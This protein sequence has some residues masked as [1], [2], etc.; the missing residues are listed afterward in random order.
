MYA[1]HGVSPEGI[2]PTWTSIYLRLREPLPQPHLDSLA[3]FLTKT[4][5][6]TRH[7]ES[8]AVSLAPTTSLFK[9]TKKRST[10]SELPIRPLSS[11]LASLTS[12]PAG[13]F[14]IETVE[15]R[16]IQLDLQKHYHSEESRTDRSLLTSIWSMARNIAKEKHVR[17][18]E[19]KMKQPGIFS[20]FLHIINVS[21]KVTASKSLSSAMQRVTKKKPPATCDLSL[22]YATYDEMEAST[23][24]TH[25]KHPVLAGILPDP[26]SGKI[27][28]GFETHQTTGCAVHMAGPFIPTVER[29]S[30][31]FV[32]PALAC[33]NEELVRIGAKAMRLLHQ[34]EM[35]GIQKLFSHAP[36]D[37]GYWKR[38]AHVLCAFGFSPSSPS[39]AP[40][41]LARSE[42][43]ANNPQDL[44]FPS[45]RGIVPVSSLRNIPAELHSFIGD[46]PTIDGQNLMACKTMVE[47]MKEFVSI[48]DASFV[49]LMESLKGKQLPP[50]NLGACL[51]WIISV[52]HEG[53]LGSRSFYSLVSWLQVPVGQRASPCYDALAN[54][55]HYPS[56]PLAYETDLPL[57][58]SCLSPLITER[59]PGYQLAA[60]FNLKEL[61]INIWIDFL[62][63]ENLL[64]SLEFCETVLLFIAKNWHTLDQ[65]EAPLIASHLAQI[66]II[67]TK[68]GLCKAPDCYLED[69]KV[70]GDFAIVHFNNRR[71]IPDSFLIAI[72][73]QSHIDVASIFAR[74][75]Q[76]EWDHRQLIKYMLKI[77]PQLSR[78]ELEKLASARIFPAIG[79]PDQ[80]FCIR[81]LYLEDPAVRLL[82]LPVLDWKN[83]SAPSA[84]SDSTRFMLKLGLQNIVSLD[85]LLANIPA[86][87]KAQRFLLYRYF[88]EHFNTHYGSSYNPNTA[89]FAFVPSK[90]EDLFMPAE[91]FSDNGLELLGF[92]VLHPELHPFSNMLGVAK[93]AP[94]PSIIHRLAEKQF[95]IS[96]APQLFAYLSTITAEFSKLQFEALYSTDFVPIGQEKWMRPQDLFFSKGKFDFG[97][98]FTIVDLGPHAKPFLRACGVQDEPQSVH[99]CEWMCR[100]P[101]SLWQR[102]GVDCYL[103]ILRWL[104]LQ[105]D[106][107]PKKAI[108]MLRQS[109]CLIGVDYA[110]TSTEKGKEDEISET[111]YVISNASNLFIIDDTIA[112]QVFR[113]LSV[114]A[115]RTIEQFYLKLGSKSLSSSVKMSWNCSG[116]P[117][118]T[119]VSGSLQVLVSQRAPLLVTEQSSAA[120]GKVSSRALEILTTLEVAS[121]QSI[122]ITRKFHDRT[123]DQPTSACLQHERKMLITPTY[124]F[125]DV[126]N[127]IARIIFAGSARLPDALLIST[128]LSSSLSNLRSKGFAVD[129]VLGQK[130]ERVINATQFQPPSQGPLKPNEPEKRQVSVEEAPKA[131]QPTKEHGN[132]KSSVERYPREPSE[133]KPKDTSTGWI[134][135]MAG[136]I[137]ERVKSIKP[138][139]ERKPMPPNL[140]DFDEAGMRRTLERS[141]QGLRSFDG[142]SLVTEDQI[143]ESGTKGMEAEADSYCEIVPGN[144]LEYIAQ[145]ENIPV[146]VSTAS[147]PLE[148]AINMLSV[149]STHLRSFALML[150]D[151]R[152]IFDAPPKS[153]H[154]FY[155][156]ASRSI[157]FNRGHTLFFNYAH[158]ERQYRASLEQI[159]IYSSWFMTFCHEL[160]HNFVG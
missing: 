65:S 75:G 126:A 125:F 72:G 110:S 103:D 1:R 8:I 31:D 137:G 57:P 74:L 156:T 114:P 113:V 151:L 99:I 58:L 71:A 121:V 6:F 93:R 128:L 4:I 64:K 117:T 11:V 20:T 2:D 86:V 133:R 30:L 134:A 108:N 129:R 41:F 158:Y 144:S 148:T 147:Q 32:D 35:E 33:W 85:R 59:I 111:K 48:P 15:T 149:Q 60:V 90:Q 157:A 39:P 92:P 87:P 12:K 138:S 52:H 124:D 81:E 154:I 94:A 89:P 116:T 106:H 18:W 40:S 54:V 97:D 155:D 105:F 63:S 29:E 17:E 88:I 5:L 34:V 143:E 79:K 73:V 118:S 131:I 22:L 107:I 112:Q 102:V 101:A 127:V 146:Y 159:T 55:T 10:P 160:A 36:I 136:A 122:V 91:I 27:F 104:A 3:H 140:G 135:S 43:Y 25:A 152:S 13:L 130:P 132:V 21:I 53:Q 69:V 120:T 26:T 24:A 23:A 50:S 109:E 123:H 82:S 38:S 14:S 51:Q 67:P 44:M 7:L 77:E 46:I 47:Q 45:S 96:D 16:A 62:E 141:I 153:L 68:K 145:V 84:Y 98:A 42:F 37:P 83:G 70:F 49:E 80:L 139:K 115:D 142:N 95:K 61:T 28:I 76:L 78:Q 100:D 66:P 9:V 19:E 119:Q 150:L 56:G